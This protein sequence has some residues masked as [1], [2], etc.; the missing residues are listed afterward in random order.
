MV[1]S[2]YHEKAV[3]MHKR[4]ENEDII[5]TKGSIVGG[6]LFIAFTTAAVTLGSSGAHPAVIGALALCGI[7]SIT[8][9]LCMSKD[10][11]QPK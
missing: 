1:A 6:G 2:G 8:T 11:P 3:M 9:A 7:G 10:A 4:E 5:L